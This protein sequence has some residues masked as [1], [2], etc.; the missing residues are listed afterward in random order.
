MLRLFSTAAGFDLLTAGIS[1]EDFRRAGDRSSDAKAD[2]TLTQVIM[3]NEPSVFIRRG[4]L[5]SFRSKMSRRPWASARSRYSIEPTCSA[6][7]K[8]E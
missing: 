5:L 2:I 1:R 3:A 8:S 4:R 6:R 7:A